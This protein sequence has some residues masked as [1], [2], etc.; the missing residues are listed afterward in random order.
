M[1]YSNNRITAPVNQYDVQRALGISSPDWGELCTSIRINKWARYKPVRTTTKLVPPITYSTRKG[2]NFG[3]DVPFCNTYGA[4]GWV[5]DMM[6]K[7]VKD[8]MNGDYV[9]WNYLKPR[10]DRTPQGGVQE[11][12]RITDFCRNPQETTPSANGD[13][14]PVNLQGYRHDAHFPFSAF[15]DMIGATPKSDSEGTYYEI[16]YEIT[17]SLKVTFNNSAGDDLHLQ[18]FID[19]SASY[20]NNIAWR[21]VLQVFNGWIHANSDNPDD[22]KPWYERDNLGTND[23]EVSGGVITTSPTGSWSVTI[24]LTDSKFTP[25]IDVN[26]FFH[27][28]IGVGCCD[29]SNPLVWKGGQQGQENALFV[30][31]YTED[32]IS[33]HVYPFYVRFKIVRDTARKLQFTAMQYY[34]GGYQTWANAGGTAPYFEILSNA[35]GAIG[36]TMTITKN[37]LAVDFIPQNGSPDSGYASLKIKIVETIAGETGENTFWLQPSNGPT[38]WQNSQHAHVDA[39]TPSQTVTLYATANVSTIQAGAYASYHVLASTNGGD[40]LDIGYFSI[41]RT[42]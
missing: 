29:Q 41:H 33:N 7:M 28:C 18:D 34:R 39:G 4:L 23:M 21:P 24:D 40:Y 8:I 36:L 11:F 5:A 13:P 32:Q 35:T 42:S 2:V 10:G 30:I 38:Q 17:H 3:L 12:Y 25:F 15:L 14:T 26:N 20:G 22:R 27:M 16:N 19:L 1:A 37:D 6:N 31:P 9:G